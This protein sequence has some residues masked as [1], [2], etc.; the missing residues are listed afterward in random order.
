M[1]LVILWDKFAL[2]ADIFSLEYMAIKGTTIGA[3]YVMGIHAV[4]K[5]K[6]TFHQEFFAINFFL[7]SLYGMASVDMT[8][9]FSFIEVFLILSMG[10]QTTAWRYTIINLFGAFCCFL[11]FQLASEPAFV[12]AGESYKPH[13]ITITSVIFIVSIFIHF[14]MARY[15]RKINELNERFA[16]IGRQSSFLMHELKTP[17][18]RLVN[19]TETMPKDP[20]LQDIWREAYKI[21]ALVSSVETMIHAPEALRNTFEVFEWSDVS[22]NLRLDFNSY[23]NSMNIRFEIKGFN[24]SYV[25]NKYLLY[26]L[27]KNMVLNA[28]EAIGYSEQK[29]SEILVNLMPIKDA[30]NLSVSN[31][32]STIPAQNLSRIFDPHFTTK[33]SGSNKGMG[34]ALAKN[35]VEAHSGI[36][37]VNVEEEN[38]TTF[39]V[40]LKEHVL[41]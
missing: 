9:S 17:I 26:Q 11:G 20:F 36:I 2:K 8:Y 4:L 3:F 7:Y 5:K 18:S 34:L 37:S 41:V 13:A 39:H 30:W 40:S 35:I 15:Q 6:I 24:G 38:R 12:A 28:I 10:M 31:T 14:F 21:S 33:I 27:I 19:K 16:H 25:G 29:T 32:N 22:E 1:T 23:L